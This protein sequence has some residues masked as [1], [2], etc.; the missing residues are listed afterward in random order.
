MQIEARNAGRCYGD[1]WAIRNISLRIPSHEPLLLLGSSGGGKSTLLRLLAGLEIPQEG[2]ILVDGNPLSANESDLRT[3]RRRL[4]FVFQDGNLFPHLNAEENITLP[5]IRAHGF[6]RS[7]AKTRAHTLLERFQLLSHIRH[8]PSELSGG[9]RQRVALARAMGHDP[10]ILVL[11]EP[12]SALDP[13]MTGEVMDALETIRGS[14]KTLV[15]ATHAT[16]FARHLGGQVAFLQNHRLHWM[17]A[18]RQFFDAPPTE[19]S[20]TYLSRIHRQES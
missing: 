11:D 17:G 19:E 7:D 14:G 9:Q 15:L 4:G 16:G 3:H 8:R 13:E 20:R 12:T 18:T 2:Q 6:S 5:L 10:E 1:Q